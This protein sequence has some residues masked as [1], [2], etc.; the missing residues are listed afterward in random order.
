MACLLSDG[1]KVVG[2][3]DLCGCVCA[4][5]PAFGCFSW[6]LF[7]PSP[8][9]LASFSCFPISIFCLLC[10]FCHCLS[11]LHVCA[12]I[13]SSCFLSTLVGT[14]QIFLYLKITPVPSLI[15]QTHPLAGN[16]CHLN[17]ILFYLSFC[18]VEEMEKKSTSDCI[19][20]HCLESKHHYLYFSN[21]L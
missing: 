16:C 3:G 17:S 21:N 9:F 5:S 11:T 19:W 2:L 12:I 6:L 14:F 18:T 7:L 10:S 8:L 13:A 1:R 20:Q 4:P 15:G